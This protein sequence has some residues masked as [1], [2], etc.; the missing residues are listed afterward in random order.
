MAARSSEEQQQIARAK[1]PDADDKTRDGPHFTRVRLLLKGE[2]IGSNKATHPSHIAR[3]SGPRL[4][5]S[6][7]ASA[8][9]RAAV[10]CPVRDVP[11]PQINQG[12]QGILD[13]QSEMGSL[14][15][16]V[17]TRQQ[18]KTVVFNS[19]ATGTRVQARWKLKGWF[20]GK[21]EQTH[22]DGTMQIVFEDGSVEDNQ[23]H[24]DVRL[25]KEH[26]SDVRLDEE[27]QHPSIPA[28]ARSTA[29]ADI[30]ISAAAGS[31]QH[32]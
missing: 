22:A 5:A 32:S 6:P 23:S 1:E 26:H 29:R 16:G 31:S 2:L 8:Q 28:S 19:L 21:V 18:T 13:L 12:P 14:F 25:D 30:A 20:P 24:S 9:P 27:H 10:S 7:N 17:P 3:Q 15:P 4:N 11:A